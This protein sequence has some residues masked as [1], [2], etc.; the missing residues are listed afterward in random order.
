MSG[1][2]SGN[3]GSEVAGA[4]ETVHANRKALAAVLHD[5]NNVLGMMLAVGHMIDMN[6]DDPVAVR[7][8]VAQISQ[9]VEDGK[10]GLDPLRTLVRGPDT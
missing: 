3:R 6:A 8:Y 9:A 10:R 4:T 1:S 5:V 7:E 2:V